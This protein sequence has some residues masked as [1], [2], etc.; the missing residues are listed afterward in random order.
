[1][2]VYHPKHHH[3]GKL[4][5]FSK[6]C[7]QGQNGNFNHNTRMDPYPQVI[8]LASGPV[9]V[10]QTVLV[11]NPVGLD[12]S[13]GF[14]GIENK[15]LLD[16]DCLW[17]PDRLVCSGCLPVPSTRRPVRPRTVGVLPVPRG[18][19]VPLLFS[20]QGHTCTMIQNY[21]LST[22]LKKMP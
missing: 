12:P 2:F 20:V 15:S 8:L 3:H 18:K 22:P 11:H 4:F 5:Y 17:Q 10:G 6:E 13:G 16:S 1:M 21:Q 9:H 7:R 19:K 14:S